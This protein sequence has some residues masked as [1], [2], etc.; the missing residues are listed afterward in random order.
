MHYLVL[1]L[2]L[3]TFAG[4]SARAAS[5]ITAAAFTPDGKQVLLG[6]QS[7]LEL[8]SWPEL[9]SVKNF[10]TNLAHIHDLS[11][12]PNGKTVLV[13]GGSPSEVGAIE[14][15]NWPE[16]TRIRRVARHDDL[17]Y[18]VAWSPDGTQW[19]SAGADGICQV[20]SA[21]TG[22][23]IA[24]FEGHSRAVLSLCYLPD[25]KTIASVS[26]DQTVQL[27]ESATGKHLRTLDN[28]VGTVNAVTVQPGAQTPAVIATIS[29]DRTVRLWQ[30]AI[31]RLM[32][33]TKL[34]SIPRALAWSK[35]GD[36]LFVACNDGHVRILNPE[37]LEVLGDLPGADGRIHELLLDP[38]GG[39]VFIAGDAGCRAL[40]LKR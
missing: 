18:R 16:G 25:G 14:E 11:F 1:F 31:G 28:H 26:A 29:E 7:G 30:P 17:V 20:F 27:W 40:E 38:S 10:P 33:F 2:W 32:R 12:S 24:R 23:R 3:A 19:A 22:E 39:R 5:P 8:R 9:A 21:N 34:A 36:R 35:S 37:S 15:L 6:S 13:A 4:A